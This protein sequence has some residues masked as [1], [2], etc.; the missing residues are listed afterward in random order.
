VPTSGAADRVAEA[1]GVEMF[2]TPTGWKFYG[3]LLDAGRVTIC[4][5]ES[6]GTESD[7]VHEKSGLSAVL[8][9]YAGYRLR[10]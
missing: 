1:L 10:I 2:E 6:A 8:L 5:E 3:T 9:R 7:H 4:V